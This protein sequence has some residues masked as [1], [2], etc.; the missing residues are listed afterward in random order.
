MGTK[1]GYQGGVREIVHKRLVTRTRG[2]ISNISSGNDS[3]ATTNMPTEEFCDR[4]D[5]GIIKGILG[6]KVVKLAQRSH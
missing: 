2:G 3:K 6:L 1:S 4:L 5:L